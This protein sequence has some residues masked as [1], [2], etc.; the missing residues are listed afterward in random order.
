MN[1]KNIFIVAAAL[2]IFSSQAIAQSFGINFTLGFPQGEFKDNLSRTGIG[3]GG[4]LLFP[5]APGVPVEWGFDLAFVNYGNETR[6]APLSNTIPDLTVDVT[7]SN[8]IVL[9]HALIRIAPPSTLFKPYVELIAGGSYMYTQTSLLERFSGKETISDQNFSDWAFS[10]GGGAG[11]MFT[12]YD[13]MGTRVM[14]DI[15]ARYLMGTKAEYLTEGDV[16][17]NTQNATVSYNTRK[18]K[19]DILLAQIGV[20]LSFSSMFL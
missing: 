15:K 14:V 20:N 8:N 6:R 13:Q 19:T 3:I 9:G 17:I 10:Y 1:K 12:V 4:E 11:L 5:T 18:S 7:R 16:I 2:M